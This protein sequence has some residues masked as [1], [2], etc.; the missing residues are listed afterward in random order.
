LQLLFCDIVAS[1]HDTVNEAGNYVVVNDVVV[2][3]IGDNARLLAQQQRWDLNY[4]EAA[5]YLQE[6]ENNDKFSTH[7][8]QQVSIWNSFSVE[9]TLIALSSIAGME[10]MLCSLCQVKICS[11]C[12]F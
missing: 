5:I 4:R 7:P 3:D 9:L 6:G 1:E 12:I 11:G 8:S 10:L 2:T